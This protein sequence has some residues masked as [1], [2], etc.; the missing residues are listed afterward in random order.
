MEKFVF[1]RRMFL[2]SACCAAAS[3]L[4]TPLSFAA[5]PG[6]KRMITIMLRGALDGL[7]L[8]QPYADPLLKQYRPGLALDPSQ[9]LIDLD[10]YFGL[11]P[12]AADLMPLWKSGELAFVHAVSTPYRNAR[13]H[14]D[15]QDMLESGGEHVADEDTGW[16]NRALATIPRGNSR[17]AIDV[18]TSAELILSGPNKVDVWSTDSDL[19]I[20]PD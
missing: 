16:L 14:F 3:P 9:G 17:K 1:S 19:D 10:G 8:V 13:S 15:G 12:T 6:D 2:A 18:N 7:G 5:V 4:V 20:T 11:H